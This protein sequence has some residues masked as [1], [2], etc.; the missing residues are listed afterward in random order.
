MGRLNQDTRLKMEPV[1]LNTADGLKRLEGSRARHSY[2]TLSMYFETQETQT[3]CGVA[4]S[5]I[6]LNALAPESSRPTGTKEW[7]PFGMYTQTQ[8]FTPEVEAIVK[9]ENARINGMTLDQLGAALK[10]FPIGVAIAH[11]S[12]TSEG[13]FRQQVTD[14]LKGP[15]RLVIVNYDRQKVSQK[16]AGHISPLAAFDER[17]DSFLVFDVA[18]YKYPPSWV[19][20]SDLWK[21]MVSPDSETKLTRGYVIVSKHQ[22]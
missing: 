14:V 19:K 5:T 8:F 1:Y 6:I 3:F 4:S 11:A 22:S 2:V 18:R 12:D 7:Q 16:G 10:T 20:T 17:T 21:A 15:D 13:A 9:R